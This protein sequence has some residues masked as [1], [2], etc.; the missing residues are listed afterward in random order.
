MKKIIVFFVLFVVL[1]TVQGFSQCSRDIYINGEK[2]SYWIIENEPYV[3][4]TEFYRF[5]YS[6]NY[7]AS[8]QSYQ[9]SYGLCYSLKDC[10]NLIGLVSANKTPERLDIVLNFSKVIVSVWTNDIKLTSNVIVYLYN[11]QGRQVWSKS[12][13]HSEQVNLYLT[14]GVYTFKTET[15]TVT[16]GDSK[17]G[18]MYWE[19]TVT[20]GVGE[21][22]PAELNEDC[23]RRTYTD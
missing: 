4:L 18:E 5:G 3:P 20:V 12:L 13:A 22:I 14:P 21:V 10:C 9:S 17:T 19:K 23:I 2:I 6:P 11:Q 7:F 16:R 1:F 8:L 15:L